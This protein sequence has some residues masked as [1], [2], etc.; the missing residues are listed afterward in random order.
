MLRAQ[1]LTQKWLMENVRTDAYSIS[2]AWVG[3]WTDFQNTFEA[4]SLGCEVIFPEDDIPW[5]KSGWVRTNN[6]LKNWK[7]LISFGKTLMP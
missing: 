2:D 5:V 3:A 6:D 4:G 7:R 1:I